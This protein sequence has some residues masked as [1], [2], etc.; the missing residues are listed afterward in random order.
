MGGMR[1]MFAVSASAAML[2][3]APASHASDDVAYGAIQSG[4]LAAAEQQLL[5]GLERDPDN[6]F[7]QL[8]LAW[9]YSQ[10]GRENAAAAIYRDIIA[11]DDTRL[12]ALPSR[13]GASVRDLAEL[14]LMR[15]E[16]GR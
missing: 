2:L 8:N 5:A 13:E 10:T 14:A 15:L 9:V 7:R 3:M 4:D 16:T 12:A 11:S 6:V 1:F